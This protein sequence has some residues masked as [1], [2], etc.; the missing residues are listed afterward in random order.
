MMRRLRVAMWE[1]GWLPIIAAL[2]V[3]DWWVGKLPG[4]WAVCVL[5]LLAVSGASW[6][7]SRRPQDSGNR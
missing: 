7:S 5:L 2:A 6:M 1:I 4:V 3:Y